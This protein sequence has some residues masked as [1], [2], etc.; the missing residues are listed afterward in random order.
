MKKIGL[1]LFA[2]GL[3][4][5]VVTGFQ[6]FT[7]EKVVDLGDLEITA[8]RGHDIS[9]SPFV[10]LGVMVAGGIAYLFGAKKT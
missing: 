5:S 6:F 2:V 10:G 1:V 7:R 4:T 3:L 8:K 9:W